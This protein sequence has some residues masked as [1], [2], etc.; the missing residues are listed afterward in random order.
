MIFNSFQFIWLFPL[1]FGGYYIF[2]Y[3]LNR[4]GQGQGQ[5]SNILLLLVS[6][7]LYMQYKPIYALILLWITL[8]TYFMAICMTGFGKSK[9]IVC[10][11]G[12][13]LSIA[14]L[15][16]FKYYNF[17]IDNINGILEH[18]NLS[19]LKWAIPIGI[20]F[21]SF[22]AIGYLVDVYKQRIPAERNFL[23]YALFVSFFPQILS[24]PIS[25]ASDLL[26]QI[27]GKRAFDE[28]KAIQGLKWLLWG[29][30]LKTVMADRL[31]LY[32]DSV[33]NNYQYQSGLS[34]LIASF[35][36]TMQIYGDFAGYSLM[37]IGVGRLM[38]FDLVNNFNRPYFAT[39]ITEF[40]KRWH[41]SLTRWL[42]TYIYI[43]LG[44]NRC[45]KIRQYINIMTTF[46]VSGIWHGANW[47]FIIWGLMHGALQC[48]EKSLGIDPKGKYSKSKRF[49]NLAVLRMFITFC[50]VNLA[51]ILFRMP[52]LE[53]AKEVLYK[54]FTLEGSGLFKPANSTL[55]F[56]LISLCVV[57]AKEICEEYFPKVQLFNNR[58]TIVRWI[59]YVVVITL[60]MLCGVFDSSQFIYVKF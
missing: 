4:T 22:Q 14:P 56:M 51:W 8:V 50:L 5:G 60:I 6:Y 13:V 59:S 15:I 57:V 40:W 49:R 3:L 43:G 29:M 54:I 47:T 30:F 34:C 58:H 44:G 7:A 20:S 1:I 33:Y 21:F 10:W 55:G 2:S 37:A 31:G 12:V 16:F 41:I 53:S 26:P 35:M 23:D 42:T 38:G 28:A 32:V 25:K 24:G 27:K 19:G 46:V 17:I 45:S 18:E 39:S 52:S 36:Y 11:A 48:I 9:K